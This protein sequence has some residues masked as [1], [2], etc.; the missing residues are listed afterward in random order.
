ME[1]DIQRFPNKHQ[2]LV[3]E[4]GVGLSGGQRSRLA[5]ARA[6]YKPSSLLILDDVLA[7][8]DHETEEHMIQNILSK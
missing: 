6:F 4:K 3:G 5:L 1:N 8:V 7:A 2:T